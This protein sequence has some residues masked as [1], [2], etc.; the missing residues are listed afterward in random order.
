VTAASLQKRINHALSKSGQQ[1]RITRAGR[2]R[3][4]LGTFY[5]TDSTGVVMSNVDIEALG[6]EVGAM[7]AWENL[8]A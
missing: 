3:V 8:V 5:V 7:A 1:L 4:E 2:A 6:R